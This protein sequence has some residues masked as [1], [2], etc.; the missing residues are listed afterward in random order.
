MVGKNFEIYGVQITGKCICKST[1]TEQHL[2]SPQVT[3]FLKSLPL[4]ERRKGT[5]LP[6]S[7][8]L[9]F[10]SFKKFCPWIIL[11]AFHIKYFHVA[12]SSLSKIHATV[13]Y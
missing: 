9:I 4:G 3:L 7:I 8:E 12:F 1:Q 6:S 2:S 13:C 5:I 11:I 10:Y